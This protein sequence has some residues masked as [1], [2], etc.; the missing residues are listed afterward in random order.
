MSDK[1]GTTA[2]VLSLLRLLSESARPLGVKDVAGALGLPMSSAHRLL[3]A[4]LEA[5]F[6]EKDTMQRRYSAGSEFF[7]IASLLAQKSS[8]ARAVQPLLDELTAKT[9]ESSI[10]SLYL[11]GQHR[12]T[13]AAKCDSPHPLRY[14]IEL[15]EQKPLEWGASSLAILAFLPERVQAEVL[16]GAGPAPVS[17]RRMERAE[18]AGR[19]AR[20]RR[21]GYAVSE[22]E[23][24]PDSIGIG[25]PLTGAAGAVLGS[26]SITAPKF[27][28]ERAKTDQFVALLRNAAA[29]FAGSGQAS[30]RGA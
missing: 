18:M 1:V 15:F 22:S 25:V 3:D 30:G 13:F 11:P 6:V 5:G 19:L 26:L 10:L 4:L 2:R 23:K 9:G 7:R 29:R 21:D 28:F 24:I 14:R 17:G 27:R 12:M 20:V 16:D 8:V